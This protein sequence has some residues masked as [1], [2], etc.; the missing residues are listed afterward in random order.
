MNEIEPRLPDQIAKEVALAEQIEREIQAM[1]NPTDE[2][3]AESD[4]ANT[5]A[6]LEPETPVETPQPELQS[7]EAPQEDPNSETWQSRYNTLQGKYSAEVPRYAA[8]LREAN[9]YI[10]QLES[11]LQ[12]PPTQPAPVDTP[13]DDR[14]KEAAELFGEDLVKFTRDMAQAEAD[15]RIAELK[16]SQQQVEQRLVQSEND[17]FFAQMDAAVPGWRDIDNDPAWLGW[18]QEYDPLLGAPRQAAIE[19]GVQNRD[20]NRLVHMF[21]L[22]L[23]ARSPVVTAN[24]NTLQ[25]SRAQLEQVTPR[26]SGSASV[27]QTPQARVYSQDDIHRLLDPRN[28]NRLPLDQQRA[29]E[30][31]IDL[32]VAEGR[33][34]A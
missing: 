24:A 11:R 21:N 7:P 14:Y 20:L 23:G 25:P 27:A 28:L 6:V 10:Q 2:P 19:Q 12:S 1:L 4:S 22:F 31:D 13:L 3:E 8:Q 15:R 34:A 5:D 30:R 18:L 9:Q 17:R 16:Q 29:I 32:A 33:I 26:P